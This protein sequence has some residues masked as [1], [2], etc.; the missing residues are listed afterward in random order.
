MLYA[1]LYTLETRQASE[2][3]RRL[4]YW[5]VILPEKPSSYPWKWAMVG[6]G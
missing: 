6:S 5:M 1:M 4:V 2:P 3:R